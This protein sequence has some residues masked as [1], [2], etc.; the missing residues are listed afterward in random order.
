MKKSSYF[1][2]AASIVGCSGPS[3]PVVKQGLDALELAYIM[4]VKPNDASFTKCEYRLLDNRHVVRCGISFGSTQ[5]AQVGY[6]EIVNDSG[7]AIVYAMN[8]KALSALEKAG[9]SDDF[10]SGAGLRQSLDIQSA[11]VAFDK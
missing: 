11:E 5:L 1:I 9:E 6:W 7:K 2:F 4:K 3:D 8:G 10:K